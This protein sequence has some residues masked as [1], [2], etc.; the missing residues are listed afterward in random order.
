MSGDAASLRVLEEFRALDRVDLSTRFNPFLAHFAREAIR[1]GG[2]VRVVP[3]GGSIAGLIVS[4]PVERIAS[5]F[6]RSPELAERCVRDRGTFGVYSE[7]PL[8]PAREALDLLHR[9]FGREP[10]EFRFRHP[11]RPYVREDLS[12]V[13]ELMREVYG[14]VNERWYECLPNPSEAGF[15][16]EVDGR[17]AGV[18]W[19]TYV[20]GHARL[21]SLTVRAPYRRVGI[22]TDLLFARL[23]WAYRS[24]AADVLSEVS[25]SNAA[26]Q[27]IA[28][29]A[30]MHRVGQIYY[31]PPS[32]RAGTRD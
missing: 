29:R 9:S 24:G 15:V 32:S 13:L 20:P 5:V 10:A 7:H 25:A 30:G 18:A 2:D 31:Y 27:A 22:G 23:L 28:G 17:L 4:D 19:V 8:E 3:G 11:L 14:P 16:S 1:C 26:S 21:H 6:T 12:A